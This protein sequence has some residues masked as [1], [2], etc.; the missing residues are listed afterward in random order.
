MWKGSKEEKERPEV[1]EP[2]EE[3]PVEESGRRG[4]TRSQEEETWKDNRSS[5]EESGTTNIKYFEAF[6]SRN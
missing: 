5:L 1:E 4:T 6:V 2:G 3:E